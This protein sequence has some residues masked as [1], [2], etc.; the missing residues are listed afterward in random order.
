[1]AVVVSVFFV[2]L[3]FAIVV[4]TMLV[5]FVVS[6]R[7]ERALQ[8]RGAVIPPD[9]AY[10]VMRWAY[11]ACFIAMTIEGVLTAGRGRSFFVPGV[12]LFL[13][14][15]ALK[16]WAITS[17]GER[18]TYRVFVLPGAPLVLRG[19]YMFVRHP[20]YIAVIGELIGFALISGARVSG[21]VA[22]LGFGYLLRV[23]IAS[24]EKALGI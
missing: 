21:I 14:A 10:P 2:A 4:I 6:R 22:L 23:R 9:P 12:V 24:E 11:P 7:N 18:W 1:V 19:P 5:E 15:K 17:L 3:T 20:N 8:E 13:A 16:A